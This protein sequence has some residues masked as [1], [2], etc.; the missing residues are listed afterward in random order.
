MP[1]PR[2]HPA[3]TSEA[4]CTPRKMRSSPTSRTTNTATVVS[5]RRPASDSRGHSRN[6]IAVAMIATLAAWPEGNEYPGE[7]E[8]GSSTTGRARCTT[9]LAASARFQPTIIVTNAHSARFR[10]CFASQAQ[11]QTR[12]AAM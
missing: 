8:I 10:S 7:C 6:T 2:I 9:S 12:V 4:K 5:T 3:T 11:R 1:T